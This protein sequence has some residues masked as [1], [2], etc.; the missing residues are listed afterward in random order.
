MRFAHRFS[1]T[2]LA[3]CLLLT[4]S[5]IFSAAPTPLSDRPD[6]DAG[7]PR[8]LQASAPATK[9]PAPADEEA[10]KPKPHLK[11]PA[12][13]P[14]PKLK[15]NSAVAQPV[16][17]P[18]PS[19][20][21]K[22]APPNV[23]EAEKK[24]PAAAK[25]AAPPKPAES[26]KPA[27][28]PAPAVK[29]APGVMPAPASS[30]PAI[31]P[32][33]LAEPTPEPTHDYGEATC[34]SHWTVVEPPAAAADCPPV[35]CPSEAPCVDQPWALPQPCWLASRGIVIGGWL[36]QGLTFNGRSHDG[37][38]GVVGFNDRDDEYQM[39]Q[40]D[41]FV[42]RDINTEGG[43]W[44]IGGRIDLLYGTDARFIEANGF[45]RDWNQA[46]M[47]QLAV[48]QMYA[49]IGW[50]LWKV[51]MG[52]F[53]SPIGY[54]AVPAPENF[55]YSHSYSF[56]Y[57]EPRT[58]TGMLVGRQVGQ[59][60]AVSGGFHRGWDN[61][62]DLDGRDNLGFVGG[63]C[64][65]SCNQ[66][67]SLGFMLTSGEQGIDN[68]TVMYSIVGQLQL[69][70]RLRYVVEH[71]FGQSSGGLVQPIRPQVLTTAEWYGLTNYLLYDLNCCWSA[72]LRFEWFCDNNGTRVSPVAHANTAAG[73]E[74][75]GNFYE[76]T[77]GLNWRPRANLAVRPE[78]RWDW[79]NPN[80]S[81]LP[82]PFSSGTR[83]DQF[84]AAIDAVLT[85]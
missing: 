10:T 29:P 47:Y 21:E 37:Y 3:A 60:V 72:G 23:G 82:Y 62:R 33:S 43:G 50:D 51:R 75:M 44:D 34:E 45:E 57:G 26:P 30:A 17:R 81:G 83:N 70:D 55:F 41:V 84:L 38:N 63:V 71:N 4:G 2:A 69:A 40:F 59:Q 66:R 79:Y 15:A 53:Y 56:L 65:T 1:E 35:V 19:A 68:N 11:L 67:A 52:K 20:A 77:A 76:I 73:E 31:A 14:P 12:P 42:N 6:I 39:N 36:D 54:E 5:A 9:I 13:P 8:V 28:Q 24:A 48:P 18:V 27:A 80:I 49:D 32:P 85:F 78:L 25:P 74:F 16:P 22:N 58:F 7:R 46:A 64:W 61:F